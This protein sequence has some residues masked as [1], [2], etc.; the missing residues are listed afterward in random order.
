MIS[1][2]TTNPLIPLDYDVAKI[3]SRNNNTIDAV[4]NYPLSYIMN[5]LPVEDLDTSK[6]TTV[7]SILTSSKFE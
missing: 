4:S 2:D 7:R 1:T 5:K 6:R 3:T